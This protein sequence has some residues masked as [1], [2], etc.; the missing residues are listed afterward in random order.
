MN[1]NKYKYKVVFIED[2]KLILE[3]VLGYL[4]RYFENVYA[5][6]NAEDG[7]ELYKKYN[8][9]ILFIDINLPQMSGVELLRKI[10]ETDQRTKAVMIT[11]RSDSEILLESAELKLT[12]YILKP[13]SRKDIQDVIELLINE[14]ASY[15]VV[16]QQVVHLIEAYVWYRDTKELYCGN[17]QIRLSNLENK[18]FE[19]M[20][21]NINNV[22]AY[23]SLIDEL[24]GYT[25][26]DKRD[27][28]K[29]LLKN[30]RRKLPK[31]LIQNEF[32]VGY[33]LVS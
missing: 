27:A 30:L 2:E 11:A 16:S 25:E 24:W 17:E 12:K 28:L 23:D 8:A 7:Y 3:R 21:N 4:E 33:K 9:D 32:G 19:Y 31:D 13:V 26:K 29:A 14:I 5:A 20:V 10:R 18:L 6:E 1:Q 15:T 22:L